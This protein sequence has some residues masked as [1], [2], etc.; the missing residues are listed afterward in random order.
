MSSVS[1]LEQIRELALRYAAARHL[2]VGRVSKL[3]F[4]DGTKL[5]GILAGRADLTTRRFERSIE[6]FSANWPAGADWPTSVQRPAAKR[7][8]AEEVD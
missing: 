7:V 5:G 3:L 4:G 1:L 6:W 8:V 2:S